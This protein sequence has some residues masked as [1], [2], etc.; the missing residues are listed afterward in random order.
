M[1]TYQRVAQQP[2]GDFTL[3]AIGTVF[4]FHPLT[5]TARNWLQR[6]C[7]AGGDHTYHGD[8]LAVEHRYVGTIVLLATLAGLRPLDF[9]SKKLP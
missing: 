5:T 9:S 3:T 6:H 1:N 4:L 7:A 8:A 2:A